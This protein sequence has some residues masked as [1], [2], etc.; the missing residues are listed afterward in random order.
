MRAPAFAGASYDAAVARPT[1][2]GPRGVRRTLCFLVVLAALFGLSYAE[3]RRGTFSSADR[4]LQSQLDDP[5][6][7][8]DATATL[9]TRLATSLA[10]GNAVFPGQR[11][12]ETCPA[13]YAAQATSVIAALPAAEAGETVADAANRLREVGWTVDPASAGDRRVAVRAHNRRGIVVAV[14][15]DQGND[16]T[17]IEVTVTV[18]CESLRVAPDASTPTTTTG[19]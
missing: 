16:A 2:T 13:R 11:D 14:A 19:S 3:G 17:A 12:V 4:R 9:A 7:R 8:G 1:P 5:A 10:E 15:R 18:P 6:T